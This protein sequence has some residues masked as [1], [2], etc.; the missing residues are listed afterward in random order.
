[1]GVVR[2]RMRQLDRS[3]NDRKLHV[4]GS[5]STVDSSVGIA[6]VKISGNNNRNAA[7]DLFKCFL[8]VG[9]CL[10]HAI[11]F[12][13]LA[14]GFEVRLW[15]WAVPAFAFISGYYGV[16]FS[17]WKIV[18]LCAIA[19]CCAIVPTLIANFQGASSFR[20]CLLYNWYLNAY[21][22]LVLLSPIINAGLDCAKQKPVLLAPLGGLM[23]WC[24]L[25]EQWGTRNWV[26]HLHGIGSQSF[27]ALLFPYVLAWVYREFDIGRRL[28]R[29]R[30]IFIGLMALGLMP[31]FGRNTSPVTLAFVVV[32]FAAFERMKIPVFLEHMVAFL[33]PSVFPV[34]LLHTNA[35]GFSF[36]RD[37]CARATCNWGLSNYG[38]FLACGLVIF[39]GCLVLDMPRRLLFRL[40][41]WC[42]SFGDKG[43]VKRI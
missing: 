4:F 7:I 24:W 38:A 8:M 33:L 32:L 17:G 11:N 13:G 36:I 30:I 37:F 3:A 9:I 42:G 22:V 10:R 31:L 6:P 27:F 29:R 5:F 12:S 43:M 21:L 20:D 14:T 1:M 40:I 41:S 23:V 26:P 15:S 25:S 2:Q 18:N 35:V 16:R 28:T 39:I 19:V 34:Y